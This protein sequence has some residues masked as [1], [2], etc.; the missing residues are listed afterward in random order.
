M[1]I[2]RDYYETLDV[3]RDASADEIKR[4]Y[5]KLAMKYHPDRNAG[6]QQAEEKF[7]QAAEAYEVLRDPDKR[8]Q[9]DRLGHAAF[10]SAA[11]A[12]HFTDIGDIF[13]HFSDIF[14]EGI[15]GDL[16]GGGMRSAGAARGRDLNAE[17]SLAFTEAAFGAGKKISFRRAD[18]C[19][20]CGG[21]AAEPGTQP[22][23]C[24]TC[25]G[26][27]VVA[28]SSGF[29][30]I[31]TTC[32]GCRGDGATIDTPC[33][34]C[35]G[36]GLLDKQVTL[37]VSVVPGI[38]DGEA[39]RIRGEGAAGPGGGPR[40]D[41]YVYVNVRPHEFFERVGANDLLVQVPVTFAQAALGAEIEVPTL[42]GKV[43]MK[44]PRGTQSGKVMRLR[45]QGIPDVHGRGRGDQLV[46]L[47]LE[48][49]TRLTKEQERTLREFAETENRRVSPARR[50]FLDK[51][52]DYL[53]D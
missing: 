45:S 6:D 19:D 42:D 47:V 25:N 36:Q 34:E 44:V 50:S 53:S 1:P 28:R 21:S 16:F 5:R 4:S 31:Q 3:S 30:A 35:S 38:A 8:R 40:G 14:G 46:R 12:A 15:F 41:L 24:Q 11:G 20:R 39:M 37:E 43:M 27:G 13:S 51:L 10:T 48:V 26:R 29:F 7:K 49:P 32:P 33:R 9:Y 22:R 52:K 17:I 23:R 18:V 2:T